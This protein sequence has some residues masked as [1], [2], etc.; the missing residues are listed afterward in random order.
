MKL[1]LFTSI[2]STAETNFTIKWKL[3]C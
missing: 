3:D 2:S 1:I